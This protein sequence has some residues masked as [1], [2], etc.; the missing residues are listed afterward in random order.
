M[1]FP[2]RFILALAISLAAALPAVASNWEIYPSNRRS[3]DGVFRG[4]LEITRDGRLHTELRVDRGD[5]EA[6]IVR[7]PRRAIA[8]VVDR[9]DL[10]P[11][12]DRVTYCTN[13]ILG[14]AC[15]IVSFED[16]TMRATVTW[17]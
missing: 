17:P 10:D 13:G 4:V 5:I 11:A 6:R 14:Q 16:R 9:F 15:R 3:A 8:F 1:G 12:R 2:M 7:D